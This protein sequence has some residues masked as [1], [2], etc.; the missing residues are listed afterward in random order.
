[1]T[2]TIVLHPHVDVARR[3]AFII[4]EAEC[5]L[6][7]T[8]TQLPLDDRLHAILSEGAMRPADISPDSYETIYLLSQ[9]SL[10]DGSD[11]LGQKLKGAHDDLNLA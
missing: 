11:D 2:D 9:E 5:G 1:M 4:A 6:G 7:L 10:R 8:Q 3:L